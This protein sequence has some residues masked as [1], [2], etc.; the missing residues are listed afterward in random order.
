[1]A[2][3]NEIALPDHAPLMI[4][5]TALVFP[6]TIQP[7]RIFEPRYRAMLEWA[8]EHDRVFCLTQLRP[9]ADDS[10]TEKDFFHTAGLGLIRAS[11]GQPDG[12]S[13]VLL[14]G[15]ARVQLSELEFEDP[16]WMA[17]ITPL[18]DRGHTDAENP[19][20][21][22]E[23]RMLALAAAGM[24]GE[25]PPEFAQHLENLRN[26]GILADTLANAMV[27]EPGRRQ[28]LIEEGDVGDRLRLLRSFLK[29]DLAL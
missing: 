24:M 6:N 2:S 16:F 1:M 11:V 17:R 20:L 3:K 13:Q 28:Q 22:D 8:L 4:F 5:P 23:V 25:V 7:L 9:G 27:R 26:P 12:T 10:D 14:Q 29:A 15:L 21:M 18:R 19:A